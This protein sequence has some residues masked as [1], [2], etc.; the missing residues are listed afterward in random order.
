MLSTDEGRD[1]D[2]EVISSNKR[3]KKRDMNRQGE[4]ILPHPPGHWSAWFDP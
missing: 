1:D 4:V 3:R 2:D